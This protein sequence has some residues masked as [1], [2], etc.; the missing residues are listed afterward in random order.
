MTGLSHVE[1]NIPEESLYVKCNGRLA[2]DE[3]VLQNGA[4]Y[5][6]EPRLCGGK[7][8]LQASSSRIVSPESGESRKR[9]G[10]PGK[11]GTKPRKRKCFWL[12]LEGLDDR[13][14]SDC[15]DDSEDD[16]PHASD[17]SC[18]SGSR[19]NENA[20]NS[21]ECSSSSV[22]SGEDMPSTSTTEKPLE[23]PEGTGIDLRRETQAA[24]AEG[25]PS[26]ATANDQILISESLIQLNGKKTWDEVEPIDLLAFD[27]AAELEA[28]G[29]DRLKM[30]L[31][32]LGLKCGGTLKERATRLFSVRG[33]CVDKSPALFLMVI[34]EL[35][36][37]GLCPALSRGG[38][39]LGLNANAIKTD[40]T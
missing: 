38:E 24:R 25:I 37:F 23:Q 32:S 11:N 10:E 28:L 33:A 20:G 2:N 14:S 4:V 18:P 27:S 30:E 36:A 40:A 35:M 16:S 1:K 15:E 19:Y 31:M 21:N 9:P 39:D 29:L 7:G 5:S 34:T 26:V 13:D 17:G 3:D 12:G 8:G 22:D 6:L